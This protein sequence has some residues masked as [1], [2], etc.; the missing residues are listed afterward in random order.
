MKTTHLIKLDTE[1]NIE[2]LVS[3]A[4]NHFKKSLLILGLYALIFAVSILVLILWGS[5]LPIF[6]I[7]IV[8][9][10]TCAFFILKQL[11]TVKFSDFK[12]SHG[13][14]IDVL[15][16]STTVRS[17]TGG[18]GM[19]VTRKYDAF[20]KAAIRLTISI[21]NDDEIHS[22]VLDG[23]TEEHEKYYETKG[24][25]IHIWGTHF[26]V[27]LDIGKEKWLCPVCGKFNANEE[28]TCER[29]KRKVL[30]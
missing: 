24:K 14:I 23:V 17:I 3:S 25:A 29:C 9:A 13:E 15:K 4:K 12:E 27:K 20:A 18:Y 5:S 1:Y 28:K 16:E 22:Y 6:V 7:G 26:P 19:Y 21:K 8:V 10:C 30:K 11:K 2:L